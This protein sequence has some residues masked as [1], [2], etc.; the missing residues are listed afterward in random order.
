MIDLNAMVIF[1]AVI[2]HGSFTRAADALEMPKSSVSR[3][4]SELEEHLGLRL[5]ERT[6]RRLRLTDV[7]TAYYEQCQRIRA[8]LEAAERIAA[9]HRAEPKGRLRVVAPVELGLVFVGELTMRFLEDYPKVDLELVL[10]EAPVD[11]VAEGFDVAFHVGRLRDSALVAR[12]LG[13]T[14]PALCASPTYI[15]RRGMPQRPS[16]LAE[17]S[18]LL[19]G[20]GKR[21]GRWSLSGTEGSESA[22]VSGRLVTNNLTILRNAA[23]AGLG[24]AVLPRQT[25]AQD[26]RAGL[27]LNVLEDWTLPPG[28]HHLVFKSRDLQPPSVRAY[29]EYVTRNFAA[30]MAPFR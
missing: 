21:T 13:P 12:K 9:E 1:A 23:R 22:Q 3:K 26:V 17:H 24:I 14:L 25:V 18:C 2:E 16:H 28:G 10:S 27:L 6:T 19:F 15:A 29:I 30:F 7:G 5:I 4:V 8:D 11:L 20:L